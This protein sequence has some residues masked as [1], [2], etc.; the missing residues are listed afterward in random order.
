MRNKRSCAS[1]Y[2][3]QEKQGLVWIW[4]QL[5]AEAALNAQRKDISML[6]PELEDDNSFQFG[7]WCERDL[8]HLWMF[9]ITWTEMFVGAYK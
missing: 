8:L 5:G 6:I 3:V 7:P 9:V 1:S 4:P 2:P